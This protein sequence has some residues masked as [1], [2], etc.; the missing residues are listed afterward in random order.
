VPFKWVHVND[1]FT[2]REAGSAE[3]FV[4]IH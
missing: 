3:R 4:N 2:R 1:E